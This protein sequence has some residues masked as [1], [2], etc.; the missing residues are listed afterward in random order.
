MQ[1][2]KSW[3]SCIWSFL[4]ALTLN[5]VGHVPSNQHLLRPQE[6]I[7][8]TPKNPVFTPPYP[9]TDRPPADVAI[10]CDYS[11]MTKYGWEPCN[12]PND[13]ECWLRN[14]QTRRRIDIRTNYET[15]WPKGVLRKYT[16]DV[17]QQD[18]A[19]DG[20]AFVNGSGFN[21]QYPGPWIQAC[22]G[23]DIEITVRNHLW[24]NGTTVHWHGIRQL[25]SVEM[26]GVN[27][28]TQCPIAP[29]QEFTYK[30]KAIQYGSSWYHSHYSLQYPDGMA[31][32]M[33]IYGPSSSGYDYAIE[34]FLMTDWN[35]RSAFQDWSYSVPQ[36]Q[37]PKMTNI[38]I[39]GK[40]RFI[41]KNPKFPVGQPPRYTQVFERGKRYL[42]RLINTS[43]DTTFVF[44]I[45]GHNVSVIG[46]DF[47]PIEPYNT[48]SVL[49]GIGQRY[50]VVIEANPLVPSPAGNYWIRTVPAE[51]CSDFDG[52]PDVRTGVI[53]YDARSTEDPPEAP[54]T[55]PLE[56]S[57]EPYDKLK[58]VLKWKVDPPTEKSNLGFYA[59]GLQN[60]SGFPYNPESPWFNRWTAYLAP[61][62]LNFSHPTINNLAPPGGQYPGYL[63]VT[64]SNHT[65]GSWV[66]MVISG[67]PIKN[68]TGVIFPPAAHP[69]HLHG[70]DFA[71][72][73]QS[74]DLYPGDLNK[75]NLTLTNPPRR[76]VVLLPAQGYIVIAFKADNPGVWLLHCHIAWHASSGLGL[77]VAENVD[78]IKIAPETRKAIDET[79]KQWDA[80]VGV[81][82]NR[83]AGAPINEFQDDSGV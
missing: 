30:F 52:T 42:L 56:C 3:L 31:G 23:D 14:V 43:L 74:K 32:P 47:V 24:W 68:T 37:R 16:L 62:W 17:N 67:R 71:L 39:N 15:Y 20:V 77:Q 8:P 36:R 25:N 60:T 55:F 64:S 11:A 58:P 49:V 22:W 82:E 13:R 54:N 51:G 73:A 40:G 66:Y 29:G 72:L 81:K 34:P 78:R 10:K 33:T 76:D 65:E 79:C 9:P 61:L 2:S 45:D 57:D 21:G 70:H 44:S 59:V 35:H 48:S 38:L 41:S 50:H 46:A 19:P 5:P 4:D 83:W 80:W 12:V 27:A 53:R 26:D 63:D 75:V 6:S 28:V 7:I 18:W 69:I 1:P